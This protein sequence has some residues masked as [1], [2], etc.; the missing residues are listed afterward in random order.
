[1]KLVKETSVKA[2][3]AVT[4]F[5]DFFDNHLVVVSGNS[6]QSDRLKQNIKESMFRLFPE[7]R[8]GFTPEQQKEILRLHKPL[9]DDD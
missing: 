1:M 4:A 7:C 8:E 5:D 2:K 6:E 3:D 9:A